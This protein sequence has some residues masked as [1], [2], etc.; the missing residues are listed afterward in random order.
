MGSVDLLACG[1]GAGGEG[2]RNV[3]SS[4]V[5]ISMK[6]GKNSV[7]PG[8]ILLGPLSESLLQGRD[9]QLLFQIPLSPDTF[10]E[11]REVSWPKG[12][13]TVAKFQFSN[14]NNLGAFS[15]A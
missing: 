1:K 7:V 3:A 13:Q 11:T 14:G 5:V 12:H 6:D 9:G 10:L 4:V 15:I 8:R 2:L